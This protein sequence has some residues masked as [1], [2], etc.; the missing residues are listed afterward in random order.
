MHCMEFQCHHVALLRPSECLMAAHP[1]HDVAQGGASLW[2]VPPM[3]YAT[4]CREGGR[5]SWCEARWR[6]FRRNWTGSDPMPLREPTPCWW[7]RGLQERLRV[8]VLLAHEPGHR[9]RCG[10]CGSVMRW[11]RRVP[12]AQGHSISTHIPNPLCRQ[13]RRPWRQTPG[14][15][16]ST[17]RRTPRRQRQPWPPWLRRATGTRYWDRAP[18]WREGCSCL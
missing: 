11:L 12:T 2:T 17:C 18:C 7:A 10:E 14:D 9:A 6:S 1:I 3:P 13:P 16:R 8:N 15:L 5:C 4:W